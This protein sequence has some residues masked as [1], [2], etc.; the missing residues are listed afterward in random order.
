MGGLPAKR[1][2]IDWHQGQAFPLPR[3]RARFR[4]GGVR[5]LSGALLHPLGLQLSCLTC[6]SPW[7]DKRNAGRTAPSRIGPPPLFICH[8]VAFS[9]DNVYDRGEGCPMRIRHPSVT[10][11]ILRSLSLLPSTGFPE[12]VSPLIAPSSCEARCRNFFPG[13]RGPK[14]RCVETNPPSS[15]MCWNAV[16][17]EIQKETTASGGDRRVMDMPP[18]S[19]TRKLPYI[20]RIGGGVT[21][22]QVKSKG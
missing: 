13:G 10:R 1:R 4:C 15:V 8:L 7:M 21:D 12:D 17:Y 3:L 18:L 20:S 11:L 22:M 5:H 14:G 9:V 6:I 16:C 2:G 19:F